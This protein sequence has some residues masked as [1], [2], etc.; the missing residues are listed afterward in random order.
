MT[1][2]HVYRASRDKL[3]AYLQTG[4]SLHSHTSR[5]RE[6]MSFIPRYVDKVPYMTG[7]IRHLEAQY[8]KYHGRAFDYS[9]VWWTPPL[10]P[11]AAYDLERNQIESKL[12]CRALV[13]LSDHDSVDAG[14]ALEMFHDCEG[15]AVSSEWTVPIGES[16]LHLGIHNMQPVR[17]RMLERAMANATANPSAANIDEMLDELQRDPETL[18]IL[19]HPLWDEARIGEAKHRVMLDGFLKRHGRYI[20]ALEVNGLRSPRENRDVER[21]AAERGYPILAGGDRHGCEP[22]AI[23]NLSSAESFGAFAAEVRSGAPTH[24][25]YMNQYDE[26]IRLRVLQVM[27]DVLRTYNNFDTSRR[28]WSDRIFFLCD[29]ATVRRVSDVWKGNGPDIVGQFVSAM[30]LFD[31]P[32]IRAVLKLALS[33]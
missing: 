7:R 3:P 31:L 2:S 24:T 5:S 21:L 17:A 14:L 9:R 20:H 29:D 32:Q 12:Q 15:A 19:N 26:P 25:V 11:K 22:N 13:S 4:V 8:L 28:R 33:T 23:L 18:I 30:R 1:Q 6:T 16:F 10:E 27:S